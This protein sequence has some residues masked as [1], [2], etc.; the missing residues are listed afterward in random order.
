MKNKI[1]YIIPGYGQSYKKQK[2]Y[3]K[4]ADFFKEAGIKP[5]HIEIDW[6]S[7]NPDPF[8]YYVDQFLK[9]Y[10]KPENS[11]VYVLGFSFG[12]IIAFLSEPKTRSTAL[13]LCSLSP[14]FSEDLPKLPKTWQGWW[15]K[16][17]DG[18][19]FSFNKLVPKITTKTFLIVEDGAGLEVQRRARSARR[20]I[21]NSS[22]F[23]AKGVK[24]NISQKEYLIQVKK[25]IQ[26]L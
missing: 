15:K 10:K 3:D 4:I 7:K 11:K 19:D 25:V 14:Y 6:H 13:I 17:F 8:K 1:A 12:A 16:N 23:M 22:L 24:H 26:E 18:S 2:G 20:M 9:Q 21:G 5:I